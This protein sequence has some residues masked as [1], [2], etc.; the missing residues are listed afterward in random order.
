MLNRLRIFLAFLLWAVCLPGQADIYKWTDA[1][2]RVHFTD[3]PPVEKQAEQ[4]KLGPIN[5]YNAPSKI[6]IDET[7]ARPVSKPGRLAS[8]VVYSTTWCGVCVR[9][10][11][12]LSDNRIRFTEYDVEKNERGRRDYIQLGARGVPVIL[13]GKQRMNGFSPGRMQQML[14]N[15][16]YNI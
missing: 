3:K 4:V 7:L 12:W 10:K 8:V 5:T 13:V 2:G 9:A 1:N 14:R 15:A 16:G 11:K 6:F